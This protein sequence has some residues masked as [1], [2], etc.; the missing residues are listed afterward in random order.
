MGMVTASKIS[1]PPAPVWPL[2]AQQGPACRAHSP[3]FTCAS[4]DTWGAVASRL[5]SSASKLA[6][7]ASKSAIVPRLLRCAAVANVYGRSGLPGPELSRW[8]HQ[9][10]STVP[11]VSRSSTDPAHLTPGM[12]GRYKAIVQM[13]LHRPGAGIPP[14]PCGQAPHGFPFPCAA[15]TLGGLA[16]GHGRPLAMP[17]QDRPPQPGPQ[18]SGPGSPSA[19][20]NP[21]Q[22]HHRGN[23]RRPASAPCSSLIPSAM[24]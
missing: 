9:A 19:W 22:C 6:S 15:Q 18:V 7:S 5:A 8:L 16:G 21:S 14:G 11:A 17:P 4:P 20:P 24:Q 23:R 13:L 10:R 12:H 3:T 1:M 2:H